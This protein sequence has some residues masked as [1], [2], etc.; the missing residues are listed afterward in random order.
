M[1]S[2]IYEHFARSCANLLNTYHKP[3]CS[4]SNAWLALSAEERMTD[5]NY[6]TIM[7]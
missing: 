7:S 1:N 3:L 4:E 5:E 2:D 6:K